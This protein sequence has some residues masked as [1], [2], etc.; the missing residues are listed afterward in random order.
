MGGRGVIHSSSNCEGDPGIE[1][2]SLVQRFWGA[3]SSSLESEGDISL[4]KQIASVAG[5]EGSIGG[6]GSIGIGSRCGGPGSRSL[7]VK[8]LGAAR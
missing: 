7:D 8:G 1:G 4:L 3:D 2:G 6:G 5:G